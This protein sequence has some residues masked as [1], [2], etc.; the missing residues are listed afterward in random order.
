[1]SIKDLV[2]ESAVQGSLLVS[3]TILPLIQSS[4]TTARQAWEALTARQHEQYQRHALDM[5]ARAAPHDGRKIFPKLFIALRLLSITPEHFGHLDERGYIVTGSAQTI[6]DILR[7]SIP[8][9]TAA[10]LTDTATV[11]HDRQGGREGRG[12]QPRQRAGLD[13]L[14][15]VPTRRTSNVAIDQQS[16]GTE[17]ATFAGRSTRTGHWNLNRVESNRMPYAPY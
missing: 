14:P 12:A 2:G 4:Y 15:G 8:E 1:L 6:S 3:D 11:G 10:Q 5:A 16:E 13:A 7:V 9:V 17:A